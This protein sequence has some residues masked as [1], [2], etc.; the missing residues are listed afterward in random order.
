METTWWNGTP[1]KR[2]ERVV[3]SVAVCHRPPIP[4]ADNKLLWLNL[5]P[6]YAILVFATVT[7]IQRT[8]HSAVI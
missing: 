5:V 8:M 6:F 7:T 3:S 4:T 1:K 2:M